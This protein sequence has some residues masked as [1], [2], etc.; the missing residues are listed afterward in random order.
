MDMRVRAR[1]YIRAST[2]YYRKVIGYARY[3]GKCVFSVKSKFTAQRLIVNG[4]NDLKILF[5]ELLLR[6]DESRWGICVNVISKR[7]LRFIAPYEINQLILPWIKNV[8]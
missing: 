2:K 8:S 5:P 4:V 1:T 7:E 6:Y 3:R